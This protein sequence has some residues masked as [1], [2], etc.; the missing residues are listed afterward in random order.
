MNVLRGMALKTGAPR[1]LAAVHAAAA[2][3]SAVR[4]L[5]PL[6]PRPAAP[7][8]ALW[9]QASRGRPGGDRGGGW[10]TL[11]THAGQGGQGRLK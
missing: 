3:A 1:A 9:R 6:R 7:V 10:L 8:P 4:A 11:L 5:A 2:G